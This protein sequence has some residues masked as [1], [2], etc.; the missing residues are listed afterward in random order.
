MPIDRVDSLHDRQ[1]AGRYDI[2]A[3]V[4]WELV[5]ERRMAAAQG[6]YAKTKRRAERQ[7][8]RD[9]GKRDQGINGRLL[10]PNYNGKLGVRP[11]DAWKL[12]SAM[13]IVKM[14]WYDKCFLIR[15]LLT[16]AHIVLI[17]ASMMA[18]LGS[19]VSSSLLT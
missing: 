14:L 10:R 18:A 8:K 15:T 9:Q 1:D 13:P 11:M 16:T 3:A 7:K 2:K 19:A 5:Q 6:D 4:S 17:R 12:M